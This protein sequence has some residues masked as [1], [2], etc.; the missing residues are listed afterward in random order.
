[1]GGFSLLFEED[2]F[3]PTESGKP[4]IV[5]GNA[6]KS[7]L[8]RRL[9]HP[10]EELRMPYEH[11][12]LPAQEIE[13]IEKWINQGAKWEKHWAY[14]PLQ[15]N[16]A[17]SIQS[18]WIK[19]GID[20]YVLE[21]LSQAELE[22][23]PEADKATLIRRLSLDLT[24]LPPT[25]EM[26]KT[27]QQDESPAAYEKIV[28]QL[29]ASPHFG[30]RW[31]ALWL[32]LARYADSK[33]YEKDAH[34]NIWRY[35]EW[36]INAFN[37]DLPFDEFTIEQLAG[38]LLPNPSRSQLIATAFNRNTMTNDE[39]GTEDEQFRLASVIDRMN[40]TFEI[41]LGTTL[42]CVQCHSHPYDPIRHEEFYQ[43]MDLFNQTMDNDLA[44]D[45]PTLS[46]FS[47]ADSNEIKATIAYIQSL[48]PS[49]EIDEKALIET[50]IRQALFPRLLPIHCDDFQNLVLTGNGIATNWVQNLTS[51]EGKRY[52]LKFNN[53]ELDGV[54]DISYWYSAPGNEA[55]I[56]LRLD[57][58]DGPVINTV[59]LPKAAVSRWDPKAFRPIKTSLSPTTGNHDLI[60]EIINTTGN[61]PEGMLSLG[62]IELHYKDKFIA[63]AP[64]N[65]YKDQL[66]EL[67][68]KADQTPIMRDKSR[69]FR[70]TTKIFER[71][72]SLV[73][74]EPVKAKVPSSFL[75]AKS[76]NPSNR[77]EFAAWLVSKDNPL[78][79]RVIVNRFWE[80]LF[81]T[82]IIESLEDFGTQS[83]KASH[84]QLLDYL[85]N[86]FM[87][88]H[89]WSVKNLLREMVTSAT[90]RQASISTEQKLEKDPFNRLLSRGSRIRLS[91]EQIRDQ[92]LAVSG[93]L[94]DSIGGKSE[95]PP[96]PEGIWAVVYNNQKWIT[97]PGNQRYRRGLYT[98][99]KRTA[100]YP[101]MVAFDS[102]SREFCQS[103]RIRTNTPLQALVTLNDP[104]YLEAAKAL[105][106]EMNQIG[107]GNLE[108]SIQ[109]G[110]QKALMKT[111]DKKS[112]DILKSLYHQA[113][114]ELRTNS[115]VS[116]TVS[117]K[118][119]SQSFRL[120]EPMTMVANAIMN[121]DGFLMKE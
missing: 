40:S 74:G 42:S 30:E 14:L 111:P 37:Q 103:R 110:F 59:D 36:V 114:E 70:R 93:L 27:F 44:A 69:Q 24:G 102:P 79:A 55:R 10:S 89:Q 53:I 11:E 118:A 54:T 3:Q 62:S 61:I 119:E 4:A 71:G 52:R 76:P 17:P 104:V 29:L 109:Y 99:W 9:I 88:E 87:D 50:Q 84:P 85:A 116:Q 18:D 113:E 67:R 35:R 38:D 7:E 43:V 100:P 33:G 2:A 101:S 34:R 120:E 77:L 112:I 106:A 39:G 68:S 45:V 23:A 73:L 107:N 117:L 97:A 32:D 65:S 60:F 63:T 80:Q 94:N 78:T 19:N 46:T 47:T 66:L 75:L 25:P 108:A 90:Y 72:N 86:Q 81:G 49:K 115:P 41:W 83:L 21:K 98:Y 121:L 95:M 91:A 51:L 20:P 56:E 8:Y 92:A 5:R 1:M 96:Q 13:M 12:A 58:V 82:G 64:L 31:A 22:P 57:Q 16:K 28:D 48:E 15:K 6:S 105:G 26:V